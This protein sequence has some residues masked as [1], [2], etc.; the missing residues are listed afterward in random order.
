ME[1]HCKPGGYQGAQVDRDMVVVDIT[2]LQAFT[3]RV[4]GVHVRRRVMRPLCPRCV[5]AQPG[6]NR[7]FTSRRGQRVS[8]PR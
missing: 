5:L 7:C 3:S 2:S 4:H 1:A 8:L 6:L